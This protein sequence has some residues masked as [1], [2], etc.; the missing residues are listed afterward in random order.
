MECKD[1]DSTVKGTKIYTMVEKTA[2]IEN[3]HIANYSRIKKNT[4]T[5]DPSFRIRPVSCS[6]T[7]ANDA[8]KFNL[9]SIDEEIVGCDLYREVTPG[10]GDTTVVL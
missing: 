1:K 8:L 10:T 4:V 2:L 9:A 6:Y 7:D 3:H 5:Y